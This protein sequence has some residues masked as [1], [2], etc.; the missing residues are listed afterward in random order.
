MSTKK[1]KED[2]KSPDPA[3][4]GA[5][6]AKGT[7]SPDATQ[8]GAAA[9][10]VET[11]TKSPDPTQSVASSTGANKSTESKPGNGKGKGG[12]KSKQ[13]TPI[14]EKAKK[15]FESYDVK[16]LYFTSDATAFLEPQF[17]NIHAESLQDKEIVTIKREEVK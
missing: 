2:T 12:A 9:A 15:L 8:A 6:A 7:E 13:V 11:G 3:Q 16:E 1:K 10:N 4:S 5:S 17:A 14:V